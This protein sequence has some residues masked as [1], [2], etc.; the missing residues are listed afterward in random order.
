MTDPRIR[1][2][3]RGDDSGM[4][5]TANVA[6]LDAYRDG[7]LRNTSIM[8][9][10][11]AFDEAA[12]MY[13]EEPGLC[14]GLHATLTSEWAEPRWGPVLP[15]ARVPSLVD[16][17]GLFFPS[18]GELAEHEMEPDQAMAEI[19]AQLDRARAA[20]L[21]IAY[22]DTHMNF[23]WIGDMRERVTR[24][25]E[26]EGLIYHPSVVERL[27][28]VEGEF[29]DRVQK[30]IAC[31][32]AAEPGTYMV[33]GHPAYDNEEMRGIITISGSTDIGEQRDEQRRMFM[34]PAI[35]DC[36][37]R[38]GVQAIRFTEI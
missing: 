31:L 20:G 12:A 34:D 4:C 22:V 23:A 36:C 35:L 3:T 18:T 5:H 38:N 24:F 28:Q 1:L 9:P 32:D 7:I 14:V 6:V 17:H 15:G 25:A 2:V 16:D 30:L 13:R 27:P 26:R 19:Q 37:Q 33:V 21:D 8:V 29:G 10:C 11:P